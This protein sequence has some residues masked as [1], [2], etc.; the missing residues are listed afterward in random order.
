MTTQ[1]LIDLKFRTTG[2][3]FNFICEFQHMS[4][5]L[6]ITKTKDVLTITLQIVVSIL[7]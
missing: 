2:T 3:L 4:V 5:E 6:Y 7:L 1:Q